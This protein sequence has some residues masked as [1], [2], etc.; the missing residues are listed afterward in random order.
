[1]KRIDVVQGWNP[2]EERRQKESEGYR[3]EF[4]T[5]SLVTASASH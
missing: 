1:M 3:P 5:G 4:T 2:V